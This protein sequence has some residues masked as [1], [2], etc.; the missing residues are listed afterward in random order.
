MSAAVIDPAVYVD[1]VERARAA[2]ERHEVDVLLLS[3]G[4]DLP[5]LI[6]YEAMPSSG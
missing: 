1:R 3:V 4:R 2:M 5:Y 6:G